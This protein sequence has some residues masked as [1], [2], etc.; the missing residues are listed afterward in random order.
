MVRRHSRKRALAQGINSLLHEPVSTPQDSSPDRTVSSLGTPSSSFFFHPH[1][2]T[3]PRDI[4]PFHCL[5]RLPRD[6][7]RLSIKKLY[8]TIPL[9]V[10]FPVWFLSCRLGKKAGAQ[11]RLPPSCNPLIPLRRSPSP[12]PSSH[13]LAPIFNFELSSPTRT[14]L[15]GSTPAGGVSACIKGQLLFFFPTQRLGYSPG[16][17]DEKTSSFQYIGYRV[18]RSMRSRENVYRQNGKCEINSREYFNSVL[19]TVLV[20][21]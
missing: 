5:V 9:L 4:S 12:P 20:K 19:K 17:P 6:A 13:L 18:S 14:S 16:F 11:R 15:R 7:H 21:K 3:Y 1:L 8:N 2:S 10:C